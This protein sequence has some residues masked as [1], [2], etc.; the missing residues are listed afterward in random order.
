MFLYHEYL[1][2]LQ[3]QL[4]CL[5][6]DFAM[7]MMCMYIYIQDVVGGVHRVPVW[8]EARPRLE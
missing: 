2:L 5:L 8:R 6:L 7:E 4:K 3:A 1:S